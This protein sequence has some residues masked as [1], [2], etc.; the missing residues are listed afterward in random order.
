M[1]TPLV[2][3]VMPSYNHARFVR[4]AIDSVLAQQGVEFELLVEDDGSSDGSAAAIASVSHPRLHFT[5]RPRNEGACFTVNGMIARARGEFIA[6]INSDDVWRGTDK[7]ARQ[8]DVLRQRPKVAACFGWAEYIDAAGRPIAGIG[9]YTAST[10]A[11]GNRSRARWLRKFFEV[12]N[13]ICHPTM[14]ARRSMYDELGGY[15]PRLRQLPDYDMW[16]RLLQR[17]EI[18]VIEEPLVRFRLLGDAN[19]SA[20]AGSNVPRSTNEQ[21]I[22]LDK[23]LAGLGPAEMIDGFGDLLVNPQPADQRQ[24]E[25][26]KVLLF[27][28]HGTVFVPVLRT[29]GLRRLFDMMGDPTYRALLADY[30]IDD[31]W[32][33]QEM[34]SFSPFNPVAQSIQVVAQPAE[35]PPQMPPPAARGPFA[36]YLSFL[37][38]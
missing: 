10:F 28:R 27:L 1:N 22:V 35:P 14:L 20:A 34:G 7:L 2:T 9:P 3:V 13:C 11:H 5:P 37:R 23:L 29:I 38:R 4:E 19:A 6:L 8:V 12:S 26:E 30:G 33:H 32:L 17:H 36:R 31:H 24:A 16:I 18:H 21:W 25:V 15:D